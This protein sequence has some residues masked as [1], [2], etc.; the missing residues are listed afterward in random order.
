MPET[1]WLGNGLLAYISW[2]N[3]QQCGSPM[4]SSKIFFEILLRY[5]LRPLYRL[6][7]LIYIFIYL[8]EV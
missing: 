5:M 2:N 4:I 3:K 6:M 1:K 8:Q 7:I